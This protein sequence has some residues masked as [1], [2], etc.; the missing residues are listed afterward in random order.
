MSLKRGCSLQ[1]GHF[2]IGDGEDD[3]VVGDGEGDCG[4]D[5]DVDDEGEGDGTTV[6][7]FGVVIVAVDVGRAFL[8]EL[9]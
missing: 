5:D 4:G 1:K 6:V 8:N 3:D 2:A 9:R 7:G